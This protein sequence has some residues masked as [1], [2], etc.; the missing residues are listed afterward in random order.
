MPLLILPLVV[1]M[2]AGAGISLWIAIPLHLAAFTMAALVC[3]GRLAA[4]RPAPVHLTEFYFW[5]AFGGMLGGMFNT[6]AA[7]VLF[8]RV[9]EYPLVLVLA[10]AA[11]QRPTAGDRD[12]LVGERFR[13]S[14]SPWAR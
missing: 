4:D 3:H 11:R 9:I 12:V 1:L 6:L 8:N 14:R 13:Q 5:L 2:I 7:P 10:L